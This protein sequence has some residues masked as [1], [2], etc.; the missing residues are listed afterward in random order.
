MITDLLPMT[1]IPFLMQLIQIHLSKN[2]KN[3][4]NFFL[5]FLPRLT[6][7]HFEIKDDDPHSSCIL[8]IADCERRG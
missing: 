5:H 4:P 8:E 2:Q 7:E 1:S 6:F 3:F